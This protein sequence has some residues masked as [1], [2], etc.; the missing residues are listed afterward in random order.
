MFSHLVPYYPQK[1]ANHYILFVNF[2]GLLFQFI[3]DFSN[4]SE[5][6]QFACFCDSAMLFILQYQQKTVCKYV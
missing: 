6:I 2:L 1:E 3:I 5:D 4:A